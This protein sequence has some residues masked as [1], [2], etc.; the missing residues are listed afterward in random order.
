MDQFVYNTYVQILKDE[1]LPAM[2]C[3]EPIAVAYAGAVARQALGKLP[4]RVVIEVS[5]NIIKNVKSVIVPHTGGMRGLEAAC[6]AGIVAGRADRELEVIAEVSQEKIEKIQRYIED[7]SMTVDFAKSDLIFDICITV[8]AGEESAF[9]RIVDYHTNVV[10]VRRG[11]Q[12]LV[13]RQITGKTESAMAD[14]SLL[15]IQNIFDFANEVKIEDVKEVLD[16]QIVYNMA[17]AE[18]G[19]RRSYGANIGRVILNTYGEKDVK[20]RARA[21]AAAGSDARMNGCELPVVINSG[22]GNQGITA[23]VPVIVYAQHLGSSPDQLYRALVVSNLSILHIKEGIGRLSA[24]CGAVGAGCGAGAGIAYLQGGDYDTLAHTLV[25]SLAILSGTICDGAKA[26]CAAKIAAAVDA[27]ILG[28]SMYKNG[29][30]FLGGDGIVKR[31]VENTIRCVGLLASEGMQETDK[32]IV[33][34]MIQNN[35]A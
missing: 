26:S 35:L 4:D 32:E 7:T 16:R 21:M 1:L 31:G 18:E 24:Y 14:K 34:L 23:S 28:Y 20:V 11:S 33:K 17:I 19:L 27:G 29:Q 30:E 22:S 10:T 5:R 12:V 13:E 3:T 15:T 9:V 2:G 6:A 25:N 8:Y